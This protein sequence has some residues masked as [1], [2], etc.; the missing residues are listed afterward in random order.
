[1]ICWTFRCIRGQGPPFT[2]ATSA[3]L[4]TRRMLDNH[5]Q[6]L[7][8]ER[9]DSHE[10]RC[11]EGYVF[12]AAIS[13]DWLGGAGGGRDTVSGP[14]R[15]PGSETVPN[16]ERSK[17]QRPWSRQSPAGCAK[18]GFILAPTFRCR[19]SAS[20]QIPFRTC[21][22]TNARGWMVARGHGPGTCRFE[23]DCRRGYAADRRR[24]TR[25]ALAHGGRVGLHALRKCPDHRA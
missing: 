20:L 8:S 4:R 15:G 25:V 18:P 6:T 16:Q 11:N 5:L 10:R 22:Q 13:G 1:M 7:M 12:A 24:H 17:R 19:R 2:Y 21:S 14:C 23:V 9:K 3:V